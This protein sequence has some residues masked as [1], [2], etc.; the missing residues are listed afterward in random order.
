[1]GRYWARNM[2]VGIA[3]AFVVRIACESCS[4]R[5]RVQVPCRYK[6]LGNQHGGSKG[7]DVAS[8]CGVSGECGAS[9]ECGVMECG[10]GMRRQPG[11]RRQGGMWRQGMWRRNAASAKNAAS[12]INV[13]SGNVASECGVMQECGV[14]GECGVREC[15]ITTRLQPKIL[16]QRMWRPNA[17]SAGNAA[18]GRNVASGN[19][20]SECGVSREC[21]F[22]S[23][24]SVASGNAASQV[25]GMQRQNAISVGWK[26][27]GP[28]AAALLY[29]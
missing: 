16:R 18:S 6:S 3:D 15:G 14:R 2:G 12:G 20:A 21:G 27:T 24:E 25:F 23:R 7:R 9:Q 1:M 10:V 26:S 22:D 19:V 17:A 4:L 11:M 29:F 5:A 8:E 28:F 13:A